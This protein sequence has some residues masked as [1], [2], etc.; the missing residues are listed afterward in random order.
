MPIGMTQA[1]AEAA[2]SNDKN[3]VM[4]PTIE[5]IHSTFVENGAPAPIR[6]VRNSVDLNLKLEAEAPLNGGQTVAFK[7]IPFD[8][9]MPRI[10]S[11]GAECKIRLDNVGREAVPYLRQ[12]TQGNEPIVAIMR[13]Y[14]A[15]SPN[16]VGRGPFRL[17]LRSVKRTGSLLEGSLLI[18][19]PQDL[20]V[21]NEVYDM[22]RFPGLLQ[23]S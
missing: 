1:W 16:I 17:V 6:A 10:G 5:L 23:A 7:A 2:A 8:V 20:R 3:E 9:D 19:R 14:L 18:A 4:L 13:G 12:A 15:S 11:L 21:L 22:V